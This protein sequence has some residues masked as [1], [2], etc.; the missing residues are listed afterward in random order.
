MTVAPASLRAAA[1]GRHH[2]ATPAGDDDAAGGAEPAADVLGGLLLLGRGLR[3]AD[4]RDVGA[5]GHGRPD[6]RP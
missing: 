5:G 1:G 4:D 6:L 3:G 2:P